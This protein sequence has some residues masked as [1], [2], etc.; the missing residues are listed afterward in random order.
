MSS[1]RI[2]RRE[3]SPAPWRG[4]GGG[5]TAAPGREHAADWSV[6]NLL[7]AGAD[8]AYVSL[9]DHSVACQAYRPARVPVG[10]PSRELTGRIRNRYNEKPIDLTPPNA[11][12]G[13]DD[14][15]VRKALRAAAA[16]HAVAS[17]GDIADGEP[18]LGL[19]RWLFTSAGGP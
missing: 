9:P 18:C 2:S 11:P 14:E 6:E 17:K 19:G 15:L 10:P 8:T 12:E 4:V 13:S 7:E 16:E 5:R 3:S 1:V